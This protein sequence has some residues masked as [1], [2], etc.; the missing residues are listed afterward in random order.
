MNPNPELQFIEIE[1]AIP[2]GTGDNGTAVERAG[3][4]PALRAEVV[5]PVER[6]AEPPGRGRAP[7]PRVGRADAEAVERVVG[8][9]PL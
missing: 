5:E 6:V 8:A 1:A 2:A 3:A 4:E 7:L 9:P